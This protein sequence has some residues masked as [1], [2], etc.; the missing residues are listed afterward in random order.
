MRDFDKAQ[1]CNVN[2]RLVTDNKLLIKIS[3][4]VREKPRENDLTNFQQNRENSNHR[5]TLSKQDLS[6]SCLS[7]FTCVFH[8]PLF[9][10]REILLLL[11]MWLEAFPSFGG[12]FSIKSS[13]VTG[14]FKI[15][16]F[17]IFSHQYLKTFFLKTKHSPSFFILQSL[18]LFVTKLLNFI[19]SLFIVSIQFQSHK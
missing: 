10:L 7:T 17:T 5:R 9:P 3:A 15:P 2:I 4:K 8:I 13:S 6:S 14:V 12:S 16:L 18:S 11:H 19:Y 1:R